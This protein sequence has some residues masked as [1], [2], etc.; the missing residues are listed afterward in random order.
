MSLVR[1]PLLCFGAKGALGKNLTYH[2]WKGKKQVQKYSRPKNPR[3]P[4]QQAHRA[5]FRLA[6]LYW[7][8]IAQYGQTQEAWNRYARQQRGP[9]AGY[10][11]Y[12]SNA[13]KAF[14]TVNHPV[15]MS[16]TLML[17][18]RN[19][20]FNFQNIVTLFADTEPG[21]YQIFVGLNGAPPTLWLSATPNPE[22]YMYTG[23]IGQFMDKALLQVFHNGIPR[24]GLESYTLQ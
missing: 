12:M 5:N 1:T 15:F 13:L 8:H 17:P 19:I 21:E 22:G 16:K 2:R 9:G 11:K 18:I 23:Q 3:T 6:D 24:S 14:Q 20:I 10:N 7:Q 4:A